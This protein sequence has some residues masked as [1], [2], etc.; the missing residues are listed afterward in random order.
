MADKTDQ[1]FESFVN[2]LE[3]EINRHIDPTLY[4]LLLKT[5]E[6]CAKVTAL[7][8]SGEKTEAAHNAYNQGDTDQHKKDLLIILD[9]LKQTHETLLEELKG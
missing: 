2:G 8:C 6:E 3:K 1:E 9:E 5:W 7:K 4:A